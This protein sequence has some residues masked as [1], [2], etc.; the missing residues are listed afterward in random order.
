VPSVIGVDLGGT[1]LLA[2]RVD[3]DL[4]VHS[5]SRRVVAGMGAEELL[6]V[7]SEA[8]GELRTDDVEAVG[9]GVAAL[10]VQGQIVFSN[11]HQLR[12]VRFDP[13][14]PVVVDNDSNVAMLAEWRAGAA[15]GCENAVSLSLGTGVGGGLVIGGRMY[16]GA[17]GLGAE[18]GHMVVDMDGPPCFGACPGR[19]CL[20][21]VASGSALAR[22]GSRRLGRQLSGEEVARLARAGE[23]RA[24]D[25]VRVIARGLGAGLASLVHAFDPEVIVVGGGV[26]AL[27][28]LLLEPARDEMNL[29]LQPPYGGR[30]TL[31]AAEFGED[32]AMMGAAM[33]AL[34]EFGLQSPGPGDR[35]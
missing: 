32:A 14:L 33:L 8:I 4:V 23:P 17:S 26:M 21:A 30:A 1:K 24:L 13:G 12:G 28:D 22:E 3:A 2:G 6:A 15:R 16:R 7:L 25:A 18:L 9:V 20:E 35:P 5:T 27:G 34:E 11:H 29:R 10:L 19:G 31:V